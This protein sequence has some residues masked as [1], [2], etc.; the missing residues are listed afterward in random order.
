M[1][2]GKANYYG[3]DMTLPQGL[4]M[5]SGRM[6]VIGIF[7]LAATLRVVIPA[8]DGTLTQ[9]IGFDDSVYFFASQHLW[10]GSLPYRDFLFIHPP[11]ILVALSPFAWLAAVVPDSVAMT[12]AT[13]AFGLLGAGAAAMVAMLLM[14]YGRLSAVAGGGTYAVWSA[15]VWSDT[16]PLQAPLVSTAVLGALV[17]LTR[18][19]TP[20]PIVAGLLLGFGMTVKMWAV[21][22]VAVFAVWLL[23]RH[24]KVVAAKFAGAAAAMTI[25]ICMPFFVLAPAD[26]FHAVI[27]V[28][29]GRPRA[30][31]FDERVFYFSGSILHHDR[32]PAP[33]WVLIGVTGIALCALPLA[34]VLRTR[35]SPRSWPETSWWS[36]LALAQLATLLVSPLF[37]DHYTSFAAPVLCLLIGYGVGVLAADARTRT[38]LVAA[39]VGAVLLALAVGAIRTIDQGVRQPHELADILRADECTWSLTPAPLIAG[40]VAHQQVRDGCPV[41]VD[42]YAMLIDE[43][44]A[45]DDRIGEVSP[46]ARRYQGAIAD[47]LRRADA[48]LFNGAEFAGLS[49]NTRA[50]VDSEFTL[51]HTVGDYQY[52]RRTSDSR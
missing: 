50:I 29:T 15:A 26:M 24:G 38:T 43:T 28:P 32:L 5:S 23:V 46:T 12:V 31:G 1:H 4:T 27:G 49:P 39:A 47:Q 19:R 41:F 35:R 45:T 9:A 22:P 13:I 10:M 51:D 21:V 8:A 11:G 2:L 33:I 40:D 30:Q 3:H 48:A 42:H 37:Y 7:A 34:K 36:V 25:A 20:H 14:R 52:W 6:I 18:T 44:D 16:A 17:L